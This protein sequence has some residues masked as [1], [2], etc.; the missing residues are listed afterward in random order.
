MDGYAE[1][2]QFRGG[3]SCCAWSERRRVQIVANRRRYCA[4][5]FRVGEG[6]SLDSET[7]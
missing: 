1:R 6:S 7:G 2:D 3:A 5:G 4:S